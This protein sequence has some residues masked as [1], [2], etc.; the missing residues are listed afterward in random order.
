MKS[1]EENDSHCN[2]LASWLKASLSIVVMGF[3]VAEISVRLAGKLSL[4][5]VV[6]SLF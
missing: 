1:A 4:G 2:V 6:I 5:I 3:P